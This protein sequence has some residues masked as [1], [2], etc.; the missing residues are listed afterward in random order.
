MHVN[1]RCAR[2]GRARQVGATRHLGVQAADQKTVLRLNTVCDRL[3]ERDGWQAGCQVGGATPPTSCAKPAG[4]VAHLPQ[5]PARVLLTRL[6]IASHNKTHAIGPLPG[7]LGAHL[8]GNSATAAV[9][10]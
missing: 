9:R 1:L 8:H 5:K 2:K 10:Q 4:H 3:C 7:P 6:I